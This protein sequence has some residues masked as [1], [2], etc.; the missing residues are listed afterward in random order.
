MLWL[1]ALAEINPAGLNDPVKSVPIDFK[2]AFDWKCHG[3]EPFDIYPLALFKGPH[4]QLTGG[5]KGFS[6]AF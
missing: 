1:P 5:A 4:K 2:I 6:P 3:P